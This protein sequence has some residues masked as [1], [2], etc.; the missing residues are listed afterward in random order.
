M[1][2]LAMQS[3]FFSQRPIHFK[4]VF[5]YKSENYKKEGV[6]KREHKQYENK[7]FDFHC[8]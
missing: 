5:D 2:V 8:L 3:P 1:C 7:G 6:V 4:I